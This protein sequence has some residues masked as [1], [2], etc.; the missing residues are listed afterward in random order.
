M[1]MFV[2]ISILIL[3]LF[4]SF[5]AIKAQKPINC[6]DFIYTT[7]G[8]R[9]FVKP[10]YPKAAKFVRVSGK[11]TVK[12]L[13][14]ENGNVAKAEVIL[15]HPLLRASSVKAALLTKFFPIV[16]SGKKIS[17]YAELGYNFVYDNSKPEETPKSVTKIEPSSISIGKAVKLRKPPFPTLCKC[18]FSKVNKVIVQFTVNENGFVEE[19]KGIAGHPLLR[20]ASV[21]AIRNSKFS[22]SLINGMPVKSYG[23]IVYDFVLRNKKWQ[24]RVIKYEIKIDK[25][26]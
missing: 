19:A 25:N 22:P 17:C 11:V 18:K 8:I 12:V 24:S 2:K 23:T 7:H 15:G 4:S 9:Y 16:L 14:D 3:F 6:T 20:A 26:N 5:I 1:E 21:N 13:I 10:E